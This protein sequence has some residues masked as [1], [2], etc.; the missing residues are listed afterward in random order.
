M[1][2]RP[3]TVVFGNDYP[4]RDGS[5]IRDYIHVMDLANAHTKALQYV[6]NEKNTSNNELFNLGIGEGVSVLEAVHAF[7][8]TTGKKLNYRIGLR[9]PG[10]V[11]AIY[12]NN[13][14]AKRKLGW[15]PTRSVEAIM[16][17]AWAWEQRRN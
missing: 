1:G 16:E 11:V 10:D 14:R 17:S 8:K 9:R 12:A 2:K 15:T 7:E 5:C 3:E 4:T 6:I 13:D